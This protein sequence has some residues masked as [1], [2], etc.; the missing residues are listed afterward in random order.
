[1]HY[2]NTL[3]TYFN[4]W[5]YTG[6]LDLC[7]ANPHKI[8]SSTQGFKIFKESMGECCDTRNKENFLNIAQHKNFTKKIN[9]LDYINFKNF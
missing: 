8:L 2:Y 9:Q 1:M 5:V 7:K 6:K 4:N 3:V